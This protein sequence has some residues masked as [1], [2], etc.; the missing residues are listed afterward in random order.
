[1]MMIQ[2]NGRL[3]K[4]WLRKPMRE[5][6]PLVNGNIL[7][8]TI[9]ANPFQTNAAGANDKQ[10]HRDPDANQWNYNNKLWE[11]FSRWCPESHLE[12]KR[13]VIRLCIISIICHAETDVDCWRAVGGPVA[14]I[15]GGK[16]IHQICVVR[17]GQYPE[18]CSCRRWN[19]SFIR[20]VRHRTVFDESL[21]GEKCVKLKNSRRVFIVQRL[22]TDY[23]KVGVVHC[24][25]LVCYEHVLNCHPWSCKWFFDLELVQHQIHLAA[26][27]V[28]K[29]MREV[30]SVFLVAVRMEV[31]HYWTDIVNPISFIYLISVGC[32]LDLGKF[33]FRHW[34]VE[35]IFKTSS[36]IS[37]NV[38]IRKRTW[39][40]IPFVLY[41]VELK[42]L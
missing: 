16:T 4:A 26:V 19:V 9:P 38:F 40:Q 32:D 37:D 23:F 25:R 35:V 41:I 6:T 34:F 22:A 7:Q 36:V 18:M 5:S 24:W 12:G 10:Q 30:P 31:V 3:T 8:L 21:R 15:G 20:W 28:V 14:K 29:E 39:I 42:N 13:R 33:I 1:M 2:S 17:R 11:F 27:G